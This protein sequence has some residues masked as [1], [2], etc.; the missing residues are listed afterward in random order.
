MKRNRTVF[1]LL[2]RKW[3]QCVPR[4]VLDHCFN[5]CLGVSG[6]EMELTRTCCFEFDRKPREGGKR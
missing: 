2:I 5:V 4:R 6:R 3:S 1:T